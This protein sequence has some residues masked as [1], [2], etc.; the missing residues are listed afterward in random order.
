MQLSLATGLVQGGERGH[1]RET[2]S[3]QS[4]EGQTT[5][6]RAERKGAQSP[7]L[8]GESAGPAAAGGRAGG[9]AAHGP[10]GLRLSALLQGV[11]GQGQGECALP[12][13]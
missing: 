4:A 1:C 8:E 6:S 9:Q 13:H 5:H 12:P 2:A 3:G 7:S 10:R 11:S